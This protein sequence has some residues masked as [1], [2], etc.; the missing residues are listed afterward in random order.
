MKL[1]ILSISFVA[2]LTSSSFAQLEKGN[3]IGGVG[4]NVGLSFLKASNNR[5]FS[6][7]INPYALYLVS[8]NFAVGLNVDYSY[9]F[10][11]YNST[12][13]SGSELIKYSSNTLLLAPVVRKYFGNSKYRPYFGITTGLA[14]D[15]Y[16]SFTPTASDVVRTTYFSYV[17][18][19]EA[20]ISYWLNE[21]VFFDLKASYDLVKS[22]RRSDYHSIDLKIGIGIKPGNSSQEK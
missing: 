16:N 21:K 8:K 22:N 5:A 15:Q 7:S 12:S 20:G 6:G 9:N 14:M 3:W 13:Q 10:V 17:L 4:G 18:N 11:K 1:L 19:P 2:L